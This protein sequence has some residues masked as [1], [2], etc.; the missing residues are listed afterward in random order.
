VPIIVNVGRLTEQ[1]NQRELI[2]AV[3]EL[4]KDNVNCRLVIIGEGELR[5][6]LLN[7]AAALKVEKDVL[8]LGFQENPF[9]YVARSAVFV[10][11]SLFEGF[12]NALAEAMAA[13]CPVVASDCITG[14]REILAPGTSDEG[15]PL[16]AKYG[17]IFRTCDTAS[18]VRGI[19]RLLT[20]QA[21]RAEYSRL[22]KERVMDFDIKNTVNSYLNVFFMN[23]ELYV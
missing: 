2:A 3:S 17:V 23:P 9:K 12:P 11:S 1:K 6:Y 15:D 22:G 21:M 16:Y 19:K 18:M 13:G 7:L 14:P 10:L 20:D 4:K 8:L 5:D